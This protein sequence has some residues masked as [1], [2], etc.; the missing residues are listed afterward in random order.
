MTEAFFMANGRGRT[1]K[2]RR[3]REPWGSGAVC[4]RGRGGTQA[5]GVGVGSR[6]SGAPCMEA[7]AQAATLLLSGSPFR[8]SFIPHNAKPPNA[9]RVVSVRGVSLPPPPP[10]ASVPVSAHLQ[11]RGFQ[12]GKL[13][14]GTASREEAGGPPAPTACSGPAEASPGD[15]VCLPEPGGC[16][17]HVQTQCGSLGAVASPPRGVAV[18]G[19]GPGASS[20]PSAHFGG[21]VSPTDP[22][23]GADEAQRL[24]P[25]PACFGGGRC[26]LYPRSR[27]GGSPI[28]CPAAPHCE[29]CSEP[30]QGLGGLLVSTGSPFMPRPQGTCH[31]LPVAR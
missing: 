19:P 3:G 23:R 14:P 12:R 13:A 5:A 2:G 26:S 4:G 18:G 16:E 21:E 11:A 1:Q 8:G 17:S 29:P 22:P 6:G 24:A 31:D 7:A 27:Q 30:S 20:A 15:S 28:L 25:W 10:G 9:K